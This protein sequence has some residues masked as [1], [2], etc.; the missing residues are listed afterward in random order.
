MTGLQSVVTLPTSSVLLLKPRQQF[1]PVSVVKCGR[2][3]KCKT[4]YYHHSFLHSFMMYS[5]FSGNVQTPVI[6][7]HI[8]FESELQQLLIASIFVSM[9]SK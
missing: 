9:Y 4:H 3:Y 8:L 5:E 2:L 7:W 1:C 6:T